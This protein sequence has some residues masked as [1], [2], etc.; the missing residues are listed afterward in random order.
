MQQR[1]FSI[2]VV[3]L[4]PG[5]KL[6]KTV[7]SVLTQT[8]KDYEIIVKDGF[9]T[10]DSV[11]ELKQSEWFD[12][13]KIRIIQS[14]DSG[15]YDGMNQAL[16]EAN[17]RYFY[18]LNCGDYLKDEN[19]LEN[20]KNEIE[21]YPGK[22]NKCI[23]YGNQYNSMLNCVVTSAPQM[24]DFACYRN[25]P[26]HQVCFYDR[27]L[28]LNRAYEP[29]YRVRADYEHFLYCIYKEHANAIPVPVVVCSYEG[30]GYS[31]SN[32]SIKRSKKEHKEI[33]KIY[34]GKKAVCYRLIMFLS[35]A[36]LRTALANS[37]KFSATYNKMKTLIYRK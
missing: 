17:G 11:Q 22:K 3:S 33:T 34:L 24:N 31:E 30:G 9:S 16:S 21:Q 26:C 29:K 36:Q 14:E 20:V 8:L 5:E 6:I 4:N 10:D 27:S 35:G 18:F 7:E 28:F 19:V 25:V 12:E 15:I 32:E 1:Y 13:T 2:I 23:F 37:K